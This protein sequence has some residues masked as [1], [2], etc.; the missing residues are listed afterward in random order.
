MPSLR[1]ILC[2][3][4]RKL[5]HSSSHERILKKLKKQGH[6][7]SNFISCKTAQKLG[8]SDVYLSWRGIGDQLVFR[9]ACELFFKSTGRRLLLAVDRPEFFVNCSGSFYVLYD[10]QP[11]LIFSEALA[12]DNFIE[13]H[14]YISKSGGCFNLRF[15]DVMKWRQKDSVYLPEFQSH[16]M[17]EE[18]LRNLGLN[19]EF[20]NSS[21][22][23][24][25]ES[26]REEF[27]TKEG[28]RR[29]CVMAGG[30]VP[31]KILPTETMQG[32]VDSFLGYSDIEICQIGAANDPELF[33]VKRYN[34]ILSLRETAS[35]L[36][37]SELF[38]GTIGGLMHLAN[39][40]GIDSVIAFAAEPLAYDSY[41]RNINLHGTYRCDYCAK[42]CINPL[43]Q[44][45]IINPPYRCIRSFDPNQLVRAARS[46]L[47]K[48]HALSDRIFSISGNTKEIGE[49]YLSP[50]YCWKYSL[51]AIRR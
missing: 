9:T 11:E 29:I 26:E 43:F 31:Y 39:A 27:K 33:G 35:L 16:S 3:L 21:N 41:G 8:Y 32:V 17:L 47:N 50:I 14:K 40:V 42:N 4:L 6:D 46:I 38:I 28:K 37:N 5:P 10:L 24:L 15:I 25:L 44:D 49:D 45:C 51:P 30:C 13:A 48:K 22:L 18:M 36:G 1:Q 7:T 34:G 12:S 20:R 19:G 23:P 2:R